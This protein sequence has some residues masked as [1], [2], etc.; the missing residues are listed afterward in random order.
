MNHKDD[1]EDNEII[2][3]MEIPIAVTLAK[4]ILTFIKKDSGE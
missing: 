1:N 2:Q 4:M 3:I